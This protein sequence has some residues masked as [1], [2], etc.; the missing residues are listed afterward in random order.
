[1]G[2]AKAKEKASVSKDIRDGKI[3]LIIGTHS[4]I[5]DTVT[6]KSLGL[7]VID[8]Q[9]KFGV[10]QRINLTKKSITGHTLIMS[11]TPIPR[12][13]SLTQY[14]DL[15]VSIIKEKPNGRSKIPSR[16]ITPETIDKFL[17]FVLTRVKMGEQ[18]YI[19]TPAIEESEA[20]DI[21]NLTQVTSNLKNI[22]PNLRISSTHGKVSPEEKNETL[23]NFSNGEIQILV[24]TSIIEVGIDVENATIMA[25]YSPERFG[26]S[27]LHQLRGRV[28]RGS[29][30]GF[31]FMINEKK[32]S[33]ESKKR[34]EVIENN[35]DGFRIAEEDLKIRGEGDL[36][37][38]TNQ[39]TKKEN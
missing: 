10:N 37:G 17:S 4:L 14:G 21:E 25:V 20:L 16:I 31:F 5:Q 38:K 8:E 28:G 2:S 6:F 9:H 27:S 19:V 1:M 24:A 22:F 18:V 3:D 15:E 36:L 30:P 34:L 33:P 7:C 26:L 23:A 29:K 32:L 11:A 13:L 12:S 39:E 35:S